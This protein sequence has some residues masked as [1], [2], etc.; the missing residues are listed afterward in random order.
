MPKSSKKSRARTIFFSDPEKRQNFDRFGTAESGFPGGPPG[1]P[2]DMFSQM[3]GGGG[4]PFGF[5][6]QG[7]RGPV[8][9]SNFDHELRVSFEESYRG[10]TR[11][12]R[13]TLD[14]TC[15]ACHSKCSQCHG[16]GVM[17]IQMGPMMMQQPCGSCQGQ[18]G[19]SKGCGSC[20]GGRKKG[21]TQFRTKNTSGCA[22]RERHCRF[23]DSGNNPE[24]KGKSLETYCFTSKWI[25][26]PSLCV[27]ATT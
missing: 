23:T 11:N 18:G 22:G 25:P 16:R 17:H 4:N 26:T 19:V 2:F 6:T 12:L 27:K 7:P 21:T 15:F 8:R 24:R 13:V 1:N 20:Q 9:R 3:F 5:P 14:K 10:T